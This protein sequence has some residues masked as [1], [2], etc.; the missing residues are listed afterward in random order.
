MSKSEQIEG[1]K[2]P[3]FESSD[4]D[5]EDD[6]LSSKLLGGDDNKDDESSSARSRSPVMIRKKKKMLN[7]SDMTNKKQQKK[8]A[9][10]KTSAAVEGGWMPN[11]S[12]DEDYLIVE[13]AYTHVMVDHILG[14]G[15]KG[16]HFWM[17]VH[18][19]F[20]VLQQKELVES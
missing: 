16:E 7:M 5:D 15:Q 18:E 11:Y 9:C 12:E 13:V 20:C 4:D 6:D 19:K 3:V 1:K 14:V 10:P 8:G 17:L 2:L